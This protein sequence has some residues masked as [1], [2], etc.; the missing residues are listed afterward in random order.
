MAFYESLK[1]KNSYS[2][3]L[4][5]C[6]EETENKLSK[7]DTDLNRPGM[8]LGK[9]QSGK[10][11][12]F[13]GVIA[14]SF[15][16][17]YDIAI[18]LTK[19]T[20]ALSEQTYKRLDKEY[21]NFIQDDSIQI[22]DIMNLPPNLTKYELD[23]KVI[24]IA[25]KQKDNL[26]KLR[27]ALIESYPDLKDKRILIIDDEADLASVGFKRTKQDEIE[28]NRI[29]SQINELRNVL[30]NID[31]LQVTATPYSLYLQSDSEEIRDIY[32]PLKPAF[33]VLVPVHPDY[34]G[35]DYYFEES[36]QD[37][38]I[39]SLLY[40]EVNPDELKT[41]KV[42]DRRSFKIEDVLVSSKIKSLRDAIIN[43]IVG[44]C[45]R[46]IQD[47]KNNL[48]QKKFSFIIHSETAKKAHQW[49][50]EIV[51]ELVTKLTDSKDS[52][53]KLFESLI[54][55]S[56]KN[57]SNSISLKSLFVPTMDETLREVISSLKNGYLMISVVNSEKNVKE[58]L[59]ENGQLKL[60]TPLN[61]FI[62][63]Q[64]LD[65][66][67]T[68]GNLIGFYYGRRP[69]RFQQ[70]TVL[71]H[72]RMY[73]FRPMEDL[74]V[75]RFYTTLDIYQAMKNIHIF[76]KA[77][78]EAFEKGAHEN[79]IVFI[80]KDEKNKIIP[81]SPNKILL[82]TTTTLKPGRRILPIGFN[83]KSR[84]S[85]Q[86]EI[87][88]IDDILL[89]MCKDGI[90][91]QPFPIKVEKA[92]EIIEMISNTYKYEEGYEWDV[93][94]FVSSLEY[95]SKNTSNS[96]LRGKVHFLIRTNRNISRIKDDGSF[97]DA[98]DTASA[99]GKLARSTALDVPVVI[100]TRQN[101]KEKDGWRDSPFW[102]PILYTPMNTRT[103]IFA[104]DL[105]E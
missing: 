98:P 70:D 18:V 101:G 26:L 75:T 33:T 51:R 83:T 47:K 99:E 52:D 66:G 89:S 21:K 84:T 67:I 42:R 56:H 14:L 58:L 20:K 48:K 78:R 49:Q 88:K 23:Q 74:V 25:K 95:L 31:F 102:W 59:D 10:T 40:E 50:E 96:R 91:S 69:N 6:I 35:G 87:D 73:G 16:K 65:R 9:I 13:L 44:G 22:F 34:I 77:L 32:E 72:S 2:D 105:N 43:F 29:A 17:G 39:A 103:V 36:Q 5:E 4:K 54:K 19:G 82:S 94:A 79:G 61:I 81:C 8:L 46:R 53:F 1:E 63:G 85:I 41:L 12:A 57:L 38:S 76:D 86:K 97:S 60:R 27:K 55:K 30:T 93:E 62:G 100:L 92:I 45:I 71:Q 15:D 11:R 104:S 68:I 7:N 24:I 80:R 37:E 90:N 3:D 28:M 64:I